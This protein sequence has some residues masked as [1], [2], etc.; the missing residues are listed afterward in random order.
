M[1]LTYSASLT[2]LADTGA[3]NATW[4]VAVA[5]ALDALDERL[6]QDAVDDDGPSGA[7]A[8]AVS[9]A[10]ALANTVTRLRTERSRLVERARRVRRL[11]AEIAGDRAQARVVC[12]EIDELATGE[13]TYRR[14]SREVVWDSFARD[15]GGE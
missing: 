11:V 3:P 7:F 10:P 9:Q 13:A 5:R 1:S 8:Q 12:A 6:A 2:S 14:R 15:L 4:W